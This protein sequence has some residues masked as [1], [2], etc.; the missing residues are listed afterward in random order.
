MHKFLRFCFASLVVLA[1][2]ALSTLAQ[3]TTTGAINGTVINPNKEVVAG[4]TVTA[5]NNGTNKEATATTDDNGGFK[6]VNLDPGT[7]TVTVNASGFAPFTN[8]NIAVEVGRST[9]LEVG[10]SLQGVTGTVQVTAEA[11]VI[12]TTQQDFATNIDQTSINELP[13]NGRRASDFVRLTPGVAPDGDF[14]INSV[15]GMSGL[16]NNNTLDGTDNNNSFFSEERG[17]T[18]IQYVVSQAAVREFQI[19][20]SNYSAEY[21]RAAGGAINTVTKSGTNDFHGQAF[22]YLRNNFVLG[23]RNP[24]ALL[25]SPAGPV[26]TKPKDFREQ[27]GGA[28]GGPI[29]KEKAFFYFT[30]DQQKRFFPGVA[31]PSNPTVFTISAAQ[32]ATL[33]ARGVTNA[34]RDAGLAFLQSLTGVVPREQNQR[35]IFPRVDWNINQKNTL[36]GTYN[37]VRARAPN[38]FETPLIRNIGRASFGNDFVNIDSFTARFAST[39]SSN[40]LNE[41]RT[42]IGREFARA[43]LGALT[44]GEQT[45][46][47][48]ATTLAFPGALP[49]IN[50]GGGFQFGYR[51]FF[52]RRK[53]PDERRVQFSDTM[54][55]TRGNH[56]IKFGGDYKHDKDDID[57]LFTGTGSYSYSNIVDYLSDFAN[58]SGKRWNTYTQAFGLAAYTLRTPDYAF[59]VQDDWRYSKNLTV[60][61]GMRWDYQS[62]DKPQF[63][64]TGAVVLAASQTRYTQAQAD[65]II[66]ETRRFPKDKNNWGP[67]VG[68]AWDVTGN[69]KTSVRAG[70]GVYY[71][72]VPNTFIASGLVNSGALGSQIVIPT[73]SASTVLKDANGNT[74]PTPTYPN[75]LSVI[76]VR[77][78]GINL[79]N[80]RLSNPL[81]H[82]AD[83][84]LEREIAPNTVVSFSYLMSQGRELPQFVDLNLPIPVSSRTYTVIGGA[85]DGRSFST[86][87]ITG[88][89][90]IASVGA[91]GV[92]QILETSSTSRSKYNALVLQANRRLTKGL[93]FQ[94]NY[95]YSH[96]TDAGQR[97]STFS[98]SSPTVLNGFDSG[99]DVGKSDLDI[100]HR[101]VASA[102]WQPEKTFDFAKSGAGKA[103]F[104]GFQIAPIVTISSGRTVTEFISGGSG[105]VGGTA[106][107]LLGSGGP[108]RAFF[109]PR[110]SFRRPKTA[111]ID[112]RLSKRFKFN[113]K[114][115]LELVGE[116][117]NLFNRA[118]VTQL[119]NT[120][121]IFNNAAST[122]TLNTGQT[123]ITPF[124]GTTEVN[125]TT[126]YGPRQVQFA[127]RF[128]F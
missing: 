25:P 88:A 42:N 79:L 32:Q 37:Y 30:Y 105:N 69:G 49:Q 2:C 97:S 77:N 11:P 70:Y 56:T 123:G 120:L 17:R 1:L 53:F 121:Y 72:R 24:S 73:F 10:L 60:N 36:T 86:P 6:V 91:F 58:P 98:P 63:P 22:Y 103:I 108:T 112:L 44:P 122:L 67:R 119:E 54:T 39:F 46:V 51:T 12:N 64:N 90:P 48:R 124:L 8:G 110:N 23:A 116:G 29:V 104:S 100:P 96:A 47:A 87:F 118:N 74:V 126:V 50:F 99:S 89:R 5:K 33:T 75:A 117:F 57:N 15:R 34:Q 65:A 81:I 45:E 94:T 9:P 113:E 125:N 127:A 93:Q 111:T 128:N 106:N 4:A 102:V 71:G 115:N 68:F 55:V 31:T 95:T 41:F 85:F 7:Y 28:I 13:I 61:L 19:N 40:L 78:I 59:F 66:A 109:I 21:G 114:M 38:G 52:D 43:F 76:P 83:I 82:E 107:G 20:T 26:A 3:S 62:F 35:I 84:T 92:G 18:R 101:F 16:L 27:F 14:G 80:S